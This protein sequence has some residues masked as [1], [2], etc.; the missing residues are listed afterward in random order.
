MMML[1]RPP[2]GGAEVVRLAR[3]GQTDTVLPGDA[4]G[5]AAA[6]LRDPLPE[7]VLA[8]EEEAASAL[9]DHVP[10]RARVHFAGQHLLDVKGQK[11][12]PMGID[13]AQIRGHQTGRADLGL[14]PRHPRSFQDGF[15]EM[16]EFFDS[17]GWHESS[18]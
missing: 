13:A 16:G 2:G 14:V 8:I 9:A 12:D 17:D 6:G 18:D 7:T 5:M 15:A 11:L 10:I 4:N 1:L 3:N